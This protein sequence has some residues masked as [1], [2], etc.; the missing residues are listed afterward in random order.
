MLT[1]KKEVNQTDVIKIIQAAMD[2]EQTHINIYKIVCEVV[3]PF[4]GKKI[5]KRIQAAVAA[6]LPEYHVSWNGDYSFYQ[7]S[8]W[9]VKAGHILDYNHRVTI[10]IG[11]KFSSG[12][13]NDGL[14][15]YGRYLDSTNGSL[16]GENRQENRKNN[17]KNVQSIVDLIE[18][19]YDCFREWNKIENSVP[20]SYKLKEAYGIT[21]P[22]M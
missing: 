5:T 2:L 14:F 6:A 12:T 22:Y 11:Y 16:N 9:S 10:F 17:I 21:I 1:A 8:I 7:L 20:E 3:K 18:K 15:H 13:G 4:D 19:T